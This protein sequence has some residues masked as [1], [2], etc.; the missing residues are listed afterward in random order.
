VCVCMHGPSRRGRETERDREKQKET[1]REGRKDKT[2][3]S[4]PAV[5]SA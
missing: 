2:V 4:Q 5:F 1:R 3:M